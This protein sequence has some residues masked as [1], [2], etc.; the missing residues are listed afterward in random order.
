MADAN[1][2]E[3]LRRAGLLRTFIWNRFQPTLQS[4]REAHIHEMAK[5]LLEANGLHIIPSELL[6][7]NEVVVSR[8]VYEEMKAII[9]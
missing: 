2:E 7:V 6:N 8:E 5:T 1:S 3:A 9:K 4:K